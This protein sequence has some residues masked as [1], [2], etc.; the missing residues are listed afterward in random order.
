MEAVNRGL[1]I[2]SGYLHKPFKIAAASNVLNIFFIPSTLTKLIASLF[3]ICHPPEHRL[4]DREGHDHSQLQMH[5]ATASMFHAVPLETAW[6]IAEPSIIHT[7]DWRNT[8]SCS[9]FRGIRD[10]CGCPTKRP[11]IP[12]L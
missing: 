7:H 10:G 12:R 9:S 8:M 2:P 6:N 11:K 4:G 5:Y 1:N 3:E